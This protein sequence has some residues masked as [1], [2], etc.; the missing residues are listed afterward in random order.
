[1]KR[2]EFLEGTMAGAAGA[3]LTGCAGPSAPV[4]PAAPRAA[5]APQL[6]PLG[7]H[8]KVCRIG[9]GTGMHGWKRQTNQTRWQ[10]RS[11]KNRKIWKR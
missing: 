9:A 2:R 4:V 8:L 3:L 5:D 10:R 11:R 7:K 6:V 1:M